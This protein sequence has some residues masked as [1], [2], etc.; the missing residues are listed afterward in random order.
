MSEGAPL[1]KETFDLRLMHKLESLFS[2][3]EDD[4]IPPASRHTRAI[5]LKMI[6]YLVLVKIR[7]LYQF[8]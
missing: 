2:Y 8:W 7:H 3:R 5:I 6:T 4:S 1:G